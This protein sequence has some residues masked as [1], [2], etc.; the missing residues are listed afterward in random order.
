MIVHAGWRRLEAD[1]RID[2]ELPGN[3]PNEPM[4]QKHRIPPLPADSQLAV[5]APLPDLRDLTYQFA[6]QE[7][8]PLCL[9]EAK[10]V[11]G[12]I[13]R[14]YPRSRGEQ[15]LTFYRNRMSLVTSAA[16]RIE[17]RLADFLQLC[18]LQRPV[19]ES[20]ATQSWCSLQP[21]S[22]R[23]DRE[24]PLVVVWTQAAIKND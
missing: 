3:A 19:S 23:R 18:M 12:V 14:K 21:F 15:V 9:R 17:S 1:P 22:H 13:R 16:T 4:S 5:T 2:R 24:V 11:M 20:P 7:E 6:I 10:V 8:L